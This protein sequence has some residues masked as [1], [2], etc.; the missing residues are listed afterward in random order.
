[1]LMANR[2]DELPERLDGEVPDLERQD[3]KDN[4]PA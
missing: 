4:T 2:V 1:M 3:D